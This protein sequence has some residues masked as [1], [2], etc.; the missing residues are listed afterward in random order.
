MKR[1]P[2]ERAR[3]YLAHVPGAIS[4]QGGHKATFHAACVLVNGFALSTSEAMP[5]LMEWN[6]GCCQPPWREA[7][8]RHKLA[9]AEKAHHNKPRGYLLSDGNRLPR[10]RP[11]STPP[12]ME[13]LA[14]A[15]LRKSWPSLES[16]RWHLHDFL[17]LE[18]AALRHVS[19]EGVRLMAER[20]L[21]CFAGWK[22]QTAFIITDG[23]RVNA[24]ARRMDGEKWGVI[25]VKA[26]TLPGSKAAWP[27]G[28]R[29]SRALPV[30]R[31][32][33]HDP[34][35][36][37]VARGC[38]TEEQ[39]FPVVL[40][41]EGGPDLLA[42]HHFIHA[43]GREADTAAV[44]M[45]GAGNAIPPEALPLFAGKRIRIMAHADEAGRTAATKWAEQLASVNA[46][47]DA[48]DFAGLLMV[49]GSPVKDLNDCTRLRLEDQPQLEDL[50]PR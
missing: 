40:F 16:P 50:I 20:G 18:L 12:L 6:A 26:Q 8:L 5:L 9:G 46:I 32:C 48:V 31:L 3:D 11:L 13:E 30:V 25:N 24:Q 23:E 22:G 33:D 21:L 44:A 35:N 42:A 39:H 28:T 34:A 41:C 14:K 4:G 19:V 15:E 2:T 1:E 10:Y 43:H 47:V 36:P 7:E 37:S 49:D 17:M 45:L 29:E 27:V 38:K